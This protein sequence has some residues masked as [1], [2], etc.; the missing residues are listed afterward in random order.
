MSVY[1]NMLAV[2][3][4][5]KRPIKVWTKADQSDTRTISGVFIPTQGD[6][7]KRWK[8]SNRGSA[9][10][11]SG[12]DQ[13]FVS[14]TFKSLISIGDYFYDPDSWDIHRVMG[15]QNFNHP[16]GF[17]VFSTEHVTGN[18]IEHDKPLDVK[19]AEFA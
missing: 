4:E 2:F 10:D 9:T 15:I 6:K 8:F 7:L 11:Y 5:L 14:D 12:D 3:P 18:T 17:M 13:L 1:G 16:G 19:E